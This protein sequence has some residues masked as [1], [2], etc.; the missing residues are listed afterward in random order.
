MRNKF[1]LHVTYVDINILEL[2]V[3]KTESRLRKAIHSIVSAKAFYYIPS[4]E[5]L[6]FPSVINF[7]I[8]TSDD[9]NFHFH[10]QL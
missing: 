10:F 5:I 2:M 3:V 4:G 1:P 8:I 7:N 9:I 6:E